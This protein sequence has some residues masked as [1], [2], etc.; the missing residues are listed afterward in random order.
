M[1]T[2]STNI[3]ELIAGHVRYRFGGWG[4]SN[5]RWLGEALDV[6]PRRARQLWVGKQPYT[7]RELAVVS[8]YFDVPITSW[9]GEDAPRTLSA[10]MVL[11][12]EE[13]HEAGL[14]RALDAAETRRAVMGRW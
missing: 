6:S 8:A 7:L 5:A 11:T 13:R 3:T 10:Y 9:L 14:G 2:S 1:I 12:R 4:T